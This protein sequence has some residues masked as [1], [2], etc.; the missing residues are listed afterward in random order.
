MT[1]RRAFEE[2][3]RQRRQLLGR[4]RRQAMIGLAAAAVTTLAVVAVAMDR[5]LRPGAFPIKELRLEGEF[6]HLQPDTVRAAVVGELG[7]N[8]F[9]LDLARIEGA[10]EALPWTHRAKVRRSWPHGLSVRVEEQRP[11]A[12]WGERNWLNDE[13]EIIQLDEVVATENLVSLQG[14]DSIAPEVWSRYNQ[15]RPRLREVGLHIE[16]ITVDPRF[17]WSL[18]LRPLESG[19]VFQV[20]L[21]VAKHDPRMRRLTSSYGALRQQ[22][23]SLRN[24]DL[25]YPNG[26]AIARR[27]A[28]PADEV[29]LNEVD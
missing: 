6:V 7:D 25:R 27:D 17:A 12:R 19:G 22:A 16:S 5:L 24:I 13:A 23:D 26:M 11:V 2:S 10:V 15:W 14:P 4:R 8:Y 18:Q 20:L 9:S 21:G 1:P 28:G 3:E 29:A